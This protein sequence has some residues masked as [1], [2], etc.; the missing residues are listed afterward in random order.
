MILDKW[1]GNGHNDINMGRY[2]VFNNSRWASIF[3][4][5]LVYWFVGSLFS[6]LG[7]L[8]I[9]SW[10]LYSPGDEAKQDFH[11][12]INETMYCYNDQDLLT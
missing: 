10:D 6:R 7:N 8:I 4:E 2:E 9:Q 11:N 3:R 5:G 12:K 1:S